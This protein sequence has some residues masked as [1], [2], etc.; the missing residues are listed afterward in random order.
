MKNF[1]HL[2][3][4]VVFTV[5]GSAPYVSFA[6]TDDKQEQSGDQDKTQEQDQ[7]DRLT[8]QERMQEAMQVAQDDRDKG[9]EMI[10]KIYEDFPEDERVGL[11]Y[12]QATQ[13]LA[14]TLSRKSRPDGNEYY[15]KSAKVARKVMKDKDLP[16]PARPLIATAL[17]NE[18]CSWGVDGEKEKALQ[19]LKDAFEFGFD[20]YDLAISDSDF[21]DLLETDE[22]K[23]IVADAQKSATTRSVESIQA[24]MAKFKSF[25]F[26]FEVDSLDNETIT[27]ESLRGKIVIVDFWGTWSPESRE[28]SKALVKL[29]TDFADKLEIIGLAYERGD[30][31][32]AYDAVVKF[33]K[34]NKVNYPCGLGDEELQDQLPDLESYPTKVFIDAEGNVR[35]MKTGPSTYQELEVI[36]NEL[37]GEEE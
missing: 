4:I 30:D 13:Q 2:S 29:K 14:S 25:D 20:K 9:V 17:Y 33:M 28:E 10:G 12:V 23:K 16:D 32:E 31:E 15:Y 34:R 37:M 21:G 19:G 11:T 27:K 8:V 36:V 3:L 24:A 22:F 18:A 7:D 35:F 1:W 5:M 6:Q 26:D